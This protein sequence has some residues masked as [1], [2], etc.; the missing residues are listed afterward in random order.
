MK[1]IDNVKR[2]SRWFWVWN[3]EEEKAFLEEKARE[4]LVLKSVSIGGYLFEESQPMD[5]IYQMDFKGLDQK[6]SEDE[7]LQLYEDAGWDLAGKLGGWYYFSQESRE[8]IDLLIFNDNASKALI[9]RRLLGFLLLV[10]F[11]MYY[12]L[13][14]VFPNLD[15]PRIEFPSFY[16]FFRIVLFVVAILHLTALVKIFS[17]YRRTKI[18][19]KE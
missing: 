10:G 19:I 12:Q 1:G 13:I 8:D 18:D 6:I 2:I 3:M 15:G 5:L 7:Y 16:F 17:M 4:G 11:P 9:Y 14:F